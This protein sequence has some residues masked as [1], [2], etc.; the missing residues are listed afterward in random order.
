MAY[1]VEI[2]EFEIDSKLVFEQKSTADEILLNV[3]LKQQMYK[4]SCL[5]IELQVKEKGISDFKGKLVTLKD[6]D[7][8][9]V[10]VKDYFI[11]NVR[12]KG[13]KVSL[14]AYSADYFLTIDKFCQAFT[15]K[16]LVDGIINLTLEKCVSSNFDKFRKIAAFTNGND[17]KKYVKGN[18]ANFL[19][20]GKESIIPYAVQ[21]NESFYDFI[22][23][24]CNRDGE[25]LYMDSNNNLCVG[26]NSKDST[27][28]EFSEDDIEYL[29]SYEEIDNST[30][31]EKSY[32]DGSSAQYN[33]SDKNN[34]HSLY[35][36]YSPEY[37]ERVDKKEYCDRSDFTN[38]FNHISLAVLS[39]ASE[40]T[41]CDSI[42]SCLKSVGMGELNM[43]YTMDK[44]NSGFQKKYPNPVNLYS[45]YIENKEDKR[46]SS[47]YKKLYN[48]QIL[49]NSGLVKITGTGSPKVKFGEKIIISN[50][51][52]VV[53][54]IDAKS[55]LNALEEYEAGYELLLLRAID[56][57]FYP[58]AMPEVRVKKSSP[59]RAIVIDDYDPSRLGRVR[60]VYPWQ[61]IYSDETYKNEIENDTQKDK[62]KSEEIEF[63]N[64][65]NS[66]P[67]LR[68]SYPMASNGAGFMFTPAKGD[69]VLIDYED[70]NVEKPYVCGAF[71]NSKNQPSAAAQTNNPGKVKSI[72]SANGHHISFTDSGGADKLI[73]N[74]LPL[75]KTLTSFGAIDWKISG[76]ESKYYGGGF[77]IADR[78][79]IYAI[80][81]STQGRSIDVL[82]P[83]G[84]IKLD[85][86]SG[87]TINA[88][89]GDVK[90]VGKNVSIEARNNLKIESGTNISGYFANVDD[91]KKILFKL[92]SATNKQAG[93]DLSYVRNVMEVFLRP[94]GGNMLIKSHRYVRV[95]AGKG[96]AIGTSSDKSK[97]SF[98]SYVFCKDRKC[99]E[100]SLNETKSDVLLLVSKFEDIRR[101]IFNIEP[102]KGN[103]NSQ[104]SRDAFISLLQGG[105][106][107][108]NNA[109][110]ASAM[111]INDQTEAADLHQIFTYVGEIVGIKNWFKKFDGAKIERFNNI[112]DRLWEFF[113]DYMQDI[114]NN[115]N[116]L[117]DINI[118]IK[119][120][121]YMAIYNHVKDNKNLKSVIKMS[122]WDDN[123]AQRIDLENVIETIESKNTLNFFKEG[124]HDAMGVSD[125]LK[126]ADDRAWTDRDNGAIFFSDNKD[127]T[128]KIGNDGKLAELTPTDYRRYIISLFTGIN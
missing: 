102:L 63:L 31:E 46:D 99:L 65:K 45:S 52:Y 5:E 84:N 9:T 49:S 58:L 119:E 113:I 11:T 83:F 118:N 62:N 70:G 82:S 24:M 35:G 96:K 29:D 123:W 18:V 111:N 36:V 80:K 27:Q 2:K 110:L 90:I 41:L 108:S 56:N 124:I 126:L 101:L 74:L 77:E 116:G 44:A 88:P 60:V 89:H 55:T 22:V 28:A 100:A 25:F 12:K 121:L 37:L 40:R 105:K 103:L 79:G 73:L 15:G 104:I 120:I 114:N 91:Y 93:L 21:Y 72:S 20:S 127:K 51:T 64:R 68:V 117:A 8:N 106:L 54:Q 10:Y 86:F 26:L 61:T 94:I 30:W 66:T 97:N 98:L 112:L 76:D 19:V 17:K 23:R 48:N 109:Y 16:T 34:F 33:E 53:Y 3:S 75:T 59:Q 14:T 122:K 87:I 32:L 115:T 38:D 47:G 128:F 95:E 43:S 78:Y 39:L 57:K 71:Y 67:W 125:F 7:N 92:L 4:P 107:I 13:N 81:G 85:A 6:R 42:F 1:K 50:E 69:E